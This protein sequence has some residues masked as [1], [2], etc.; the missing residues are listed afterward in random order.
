M[1]VEL[2]CT[3]LHMYYYFFN[4]YSNYYYYILSSYKSVLLYIVHE[5]FYR[6]QMC[7]CGSG[8]FLPA[9]Y[10][11]IIIII[12]IVITSITVAMH[13]VSDIPCVSVYCYY[14]YYCGH[15]LS[16]WYTL[17]VRL[18]L[19]LVLLRPC[20]QWVMYP[21]GPHRQCGAQGLC[22]YNTNRFSSWLLQTH[23]CHGICTVQ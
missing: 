14:S 1:I 10:N 2:K 23:L 8:Y 5:S 7:A 12:I 20:T 9:S 15:A 17:C 21:V 18:V 4:Y 11:S 6:R 13:S 22:C 3:T 19:L 16:E